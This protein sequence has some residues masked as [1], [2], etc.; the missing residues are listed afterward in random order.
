MMSN[1]ALQAASA[2]VACPQPYL[3]ETLGAA[4]DINGAATATATTS[5]STRGAP[6]TVI[7]GTH[8]FDFLYFFVYSSLF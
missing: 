2:A 5:R 6:N 3:G 7:K 4:Q 1:F 8:S